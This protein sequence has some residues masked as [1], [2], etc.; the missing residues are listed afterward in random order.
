MDPLSVSVHYFV[1]SNILYQWV[2][3][4]STLLCVGRLFFF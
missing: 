4:V 2:Y 1:Y 3:T